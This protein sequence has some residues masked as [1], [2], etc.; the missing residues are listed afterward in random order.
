MKVRFCQ[1]AFLSLPSFPYL[2]LP[3]YLLYYLFI[4]LFILS[5]VYLVIIYF[6]LLLFVFYPCLLPVL[7]TYYPYLSISIAHL[8]CCRLSLIISFCP[9]ILLSIY[10]RFSILPFFYIL[11]LFFFLLLLRIRKVL[12]LFDFSLV[13]SFL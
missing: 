4:I 8:S 5:L 3:A 2:T 9:L 6:L 7:L 12:L 11:F 13:L 10:L 1:S